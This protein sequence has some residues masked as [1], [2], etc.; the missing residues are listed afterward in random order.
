MKQSKILKVLL[1]VLVGV[2]TCVS[3]LCRGKI[4]KKDE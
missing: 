4:L 2:G 1:L 3:F